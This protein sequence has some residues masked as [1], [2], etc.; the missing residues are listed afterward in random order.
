MLIHPKGAKI[1]I[2]GEAWGKEEAKEGKPFVGLAG[3][4]LDGILEEV[5]L[6]RQRIGI[7]NIIHERPPN[8]DFSTYYEKVK[9]KIQPSQKLRD[10]YQR[11]YQEIKEVKPNVIVALGREPLKALTDKDKI[12]FW[13]GSVLDT[14]HGKVIPTYHPAAVLRN[15]NYRPAVVCDLPIVTGKQ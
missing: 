6:V 14:D 4:V 5:G 13:R 15:W 12:S 10:A 9:G 11:L 2:V 7:T 3:R 1:L 8:N